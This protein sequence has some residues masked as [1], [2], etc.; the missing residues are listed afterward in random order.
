MFA[1]DKVLEENNLPDHPKRTNS[2]T[3]G[4]GGLDWGSWVT[5]RGPEEKITS[6]SLAFFGDICLNLPAL[7][8]RAEKSDVI[9]KR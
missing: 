6:P 3:V 7:L 4:G 9:S 8:P 5:L 1:Y 2:G